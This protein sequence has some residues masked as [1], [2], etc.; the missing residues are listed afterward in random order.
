MGKGQG[1]RPLG[2]TI[3]IRKDDITFEISCEGGHDVG[4]WLVAGLNISGVTYSGFV[5]SVSLVSRT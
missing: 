5:F 1:K 4:S 3:K 2:E